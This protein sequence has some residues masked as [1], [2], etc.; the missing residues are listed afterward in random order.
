MAT[1]ETLEDFYQNKFNWIPDD[2]QK[3]CGHFNVFKRENCF[4]P[5]NTP[6][7]YSRRDFYKISL[8][9]DSNIIHYADKSLATTGPTLF[10]S[11][12]RVPFT[13]ESRS[14]PEED[15]TGFF[16]IF[17]ESFIPDKNFVDLPMFTVG[18]NPAYALT[19]EQD[20]EISALFVKMLREINSDYIYKY[21]LLKNYVTEMVHYAVKMQP[22][23]I[24][25]RHPDANSRITAV[26]TELLERQFPIESPSQQF[27][28]RSASDYAKNLSVHVNHLNRAVK[29][30][31]GK[32]TT[33]HISFR[34]LSEAK[35]LLKHT[36]W[37]ISMISYCLGFEE[38][39][40]FS[41]FFHKQTRLT[42]TAFRIV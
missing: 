26:F 11:N 30:V 1:L 4:G 36:D 32:T 41:N 42:P 39:S 23:N 33:E 35:A 13:F 5:G 9:R 2:L 34:M 14:T 27:S 29:Q 25:Y 7:V 12:P 19:R 8:A 15:T 28:L 22:A 3:G 10:F 20:E 17:T 40:H 37:N 24:L 16:C 21:D 18:G 31:T 6:P 38:P